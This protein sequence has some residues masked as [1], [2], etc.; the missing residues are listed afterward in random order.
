[1][2]GFLSDV[3]FLVDCGAVPT[4]VAGNS[5]KRT[6]HLK[7]EVGIQIRATHVNESGPYDRRFRR[8]R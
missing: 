8:G 2:V 3:L 7:C 6:P 1:M 4:V 5:S